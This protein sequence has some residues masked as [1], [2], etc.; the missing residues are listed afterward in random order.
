MID[1]RH[2]GK[3][4]PVAALE[5]EAGR[6]R[7]F[8]RAIGETDPVYTD[9]AAARAAGYRSLPVPP[10][11]LIAGELEADTVRAALVEMGVD[12]ERI[13]HGEQRFTYLGAICAGDT[14][15]FESRFSDIYGKR[16]GALEFIVKETNVT[17]Q[18]GARVA[19]MRSVIVVR[20]GR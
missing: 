18:H 6:L 7:Q 12:I 16:N 15:A 13:L 4:L 20:G 9:L 11:F 2:V 1:R 5:I 3:K 8:A 14:V 10:T 17:N 19:E